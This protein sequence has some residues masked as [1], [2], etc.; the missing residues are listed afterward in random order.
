MVSIPPSVQQ[1]RRF[2]HP[3]SAA[4]D[5]AERPAAMWAGL[6]DGLLRPILRAYPASALPAALTQLSCWSAEL[7]LRPA[8]VL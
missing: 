6:S 4:M 5:F 8:V 1:L 2:R 3:P 7:G